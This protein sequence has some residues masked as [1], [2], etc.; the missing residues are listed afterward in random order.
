M[1]DWLA[2]LPLLLLLLL[3]FLL[4]LERGGLG[5]R[6]GGAVCALTRVD[7]DGAAATIVIADVN[8]PG[9][10][11]CSRAISPLLLLLLSCVLKSFQF[12]YVLFIDTARYFQMLK[13]LMLSL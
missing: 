5:V 4:L 7:V 9:A 2:L 6:R 3:L 12:F 13:S 10:T 8:N 1:R 11:G